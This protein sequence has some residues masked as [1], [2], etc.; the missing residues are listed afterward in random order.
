MQLRTMLLFVTA[1]LAAMSAQADQIIYCRTCT[2]PPGGGSCSFN[3]KIG[4]W[5]P[6]N[7]GFP[8]YN[9]CVIPGIANVTEILPNDAFFTPE[10]IRA[11]SRSLALNEWRLTPIAGVAFSRLYDERYATRTVEVVPPVEGG[12]GLVRVEMVKEPRDVASPEATLSLALSRRGRGGA[13]IFG[14]GVGSAGSARGYL[15]YGH[16]LGPIWLQLG[17]AI[18]Q[19][20]RLSSSIDRFNAG[21]VNPDL[22]VVKALRVAPFIGISYALGGGNPGE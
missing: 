14:F 22:S 1:L 6:P 11:H 18:G 9:R 20:D 3:G 12:P 4:T 13:A 5:S 15:G 2:V 7:P 17:A 16:R 8:G 10:E 21:A 19:V